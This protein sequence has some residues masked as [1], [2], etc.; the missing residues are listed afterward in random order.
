[1]ISLSLYTDS[2]KR[3][4]QYQ[5]YDYEMK[6]AKL[7]GKRKRLEFEMK[8]KKGIFKCSKCDRE[9]QKNSRS[10]GCKYHNKIIDEAMVEKLGN[11]FERY[12]RKFT[13]HLL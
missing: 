6:I 12:T 8:N 5:R 7:K 13:C 1:M 3:K 4:L 11:G 10:R 2:K 9:G